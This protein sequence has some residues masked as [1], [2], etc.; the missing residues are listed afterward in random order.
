MDKSRVDEKL[1]ALY[2]RLNGYLTSGLILH[3]PKDTKVNSEID[4]I[5]ISFKNHNQNDRI[6]G[7]SEILNIPEDCFADI[8]IGEVKGGKYKLQFNQSITRSNENIEKL[9]NWIGFIN[10][11]HLKEVIEEFKIK[12]T[13]KELNNS[14][15]IP[16]IKY[17]D[18]DKI[19]SIRPLVFAPERSTPKKNQPFFINGDKI[20]QYCCDCL[21][22]IIKRETCA[23]NYRAINNWGEQFEDL[24]KFLKIQKPGKYPTIT[25][26]YNHYSKNN[27]EN[28]K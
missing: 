6:I 17:N 1:V 24:V 4:I 21:N 26:I 11:I 15:E 20:I 2:L 13:P 19:F 28:I 5:A 27:Y 8:I 9:L 12:I 7:K 25:D 23:T 16:L 10:P 22:P 14:N 18:G 3:S